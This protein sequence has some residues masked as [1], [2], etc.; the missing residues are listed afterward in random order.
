MPQIQHFHDYILE[1]HQPFWKL[2]FMSILWAFREQTF[3][4]CTWHH[5]SLFTYCYQ[6]QDQEVHIWQHALL[7]LVW[8]IIIAPRIYHKST[9]GAYRMNWKV[10]LGGESG[11][12]FWHCLND[13]SCWG[14]SLPSS[15]ASVR[16]HHS[17]V[18]C[19]PVVERKSVVNKILRMKILQITR[20]PQKPQNLH[21]S[22]ICMY[23]VCS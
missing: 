10:E 9:I 6:E 14:K 7:S 1:E 18:S 20:W 5:Y 4:T 21:P 8:C 15:F 13:R 11:G 2:D 23:T 3:C 17:S 12:H 22:N 19:S 16:C